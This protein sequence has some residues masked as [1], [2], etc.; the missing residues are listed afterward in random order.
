[1]SSP[2]HDPHPD[3]SHSKMPHNSQ[4]FERYDLTGNRIRMWTIAARRALASTFRRLVRIGNVASETQLPGTEEKLGDKAVKVPGKGVE[5]LEAH[6]EKA[7]IENQLKSAQTQTEFLKQELI[8]EQID[9]T[10]EDTR[11]KKLNNAAR[12]VEI[13]E[14]LEEITI[15]KTIANQGYIIS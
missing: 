4:S 13:R 3:E 5:F 15:G 9:N 11:A 6:I 14:R 2:E 7:P 8:R 10:R 12:E 1:M